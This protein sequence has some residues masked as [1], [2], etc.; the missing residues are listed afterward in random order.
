MAEKLVKP[1]TERFL[2]HQ[3]WS[4]K[5]GFFY[6]DEV[7]PFTRIHHTKEDRMATVF[8]V[9][10][11]GVGFDTYKQAVYTH[12]D[13]QEYAIRP[14]ARK[15]VSLAWLESNSLAYV[16]TVVDEVAERI[17]EARDFD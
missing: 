10:L 14:I 2:P 9:N 4:T 6:I 17:Y 15:Q 11:Q 16:C 3:I 5:Y 8:P 7:M 1:E 12:I 13:E